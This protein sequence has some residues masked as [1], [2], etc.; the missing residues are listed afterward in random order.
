MPD[1]DAPGWVSTPGIAAP[2]I[3]VGDEEERD[4]RQR[5]AHRAPRRL[6]QNHD[7]D[8][9]H[10]DV[11]GQRIADAEGQI[12]EDPR[13]VEG[14]DHTGDGEHPVPQG[15]AQ[16]RQRPA[17][18]RAAP[19]G[20]EGEEHQPQRERQMHAPVQRRLR[21]AEAGG[22]VV[23]ARQHEERRGR[24]P[25][26]RGRERAEAHLGVE[27]LLQLLELR[28]GQLLGAIGRRLVV[29]VAQPRVAGRS[30]VVRHRSGSG[31]GVGPPRV[32]R[33]TP[34]VGQAAARAEGRGP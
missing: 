12:L 15:Q 17:P 25:A 28:L 26:E 34:M 29:E 3:G 20:G 8:R 6:Q 1:H 7:Q 2:E 32:R 23:V 27:A 5:P 9:A 18:D 24:E 30:P 11:D 31:W 16:R 19:P 13:H 21:D 33:A 14:R 10:R 22:V 4:D